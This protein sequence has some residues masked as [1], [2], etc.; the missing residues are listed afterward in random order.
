VAGIRGTTVIVNLP[1]SSKAVSESLDALF[2]GIF[3]IYK[4]LRGYGH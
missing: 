1:G 2:P 4:M 3:H